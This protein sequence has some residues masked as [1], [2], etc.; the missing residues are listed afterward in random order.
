MP[1]SGCVFFFKDYN[2][3][4]NNNN[5]N[6]NVNNQNNRNHN[7]NHICDNKKKIPWFFALFCGIQELLVA[8]F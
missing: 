2:D 6:S 4:Y 7:H 1:V 3:D 8:H 5:D